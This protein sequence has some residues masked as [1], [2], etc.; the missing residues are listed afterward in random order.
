[1]QAEQENLNR[2]FAINLK[3]YYELKVVLV[4]VKLTDSY[5]CLLEKT[6]ALFELEDKK[7]QN[8]RLRKYFPQSDIVTET[9]DGK[10]DKTLN[11]L[12]FSKANIRIYKKK[13]FY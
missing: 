12:N 11:E 2:K 8:C 1:M 10:E 4:Q 6:L 3:V 5:K 13:S 9:Y 7:L